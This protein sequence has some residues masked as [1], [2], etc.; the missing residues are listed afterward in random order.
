MPVYI[1]DQNGERLYN[2]ESM[3]MMSVMNNL[4][5]CKMQG[6]NSQYVLGSYNSYDEAMDVLNAIV[7]WMDGEGCEFPFEGMEFVFEMPEAKEL[8]F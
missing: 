4:I 3:T 1:K 5:V 2:V 7:A 8:L 6:E